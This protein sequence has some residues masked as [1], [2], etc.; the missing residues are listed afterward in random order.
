MVL[1]GSCHVSQRLTPAWLLPLFLLQLAVAKYASLA[2]KLLR[3]YNG[4]ECKEPEPGKF[5]LAF[6]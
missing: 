1:P 4:Y 3:R 6:R 2:R 5:T